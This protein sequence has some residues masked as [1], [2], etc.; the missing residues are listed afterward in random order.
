MSAATVH[1]DEMRGVMSLLY[2]QSDELPYYFNPDPTTSPP[3]LPHSRASYAAPGTRSLRGWYPL[4]FV[5]ACTQDEQYMF[6]F[7]SEANYAAIC[8]PLHGRAR[9]C[10]EILDAMRAR[11]VTADG[12]MY[13]RYP[14]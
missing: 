6:A 8:R 9:S 11:R 1:T 12:I 4:Y 3:H 14:S 13:S 7:R 2:F 10:I 5:C